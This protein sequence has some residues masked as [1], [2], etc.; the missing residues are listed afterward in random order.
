MEATP[1]AHQQTTGLRRYGMY[2]CMYV[3]MCICVSAHTRTRAH[4]HTHTHTHTG[5]LLSRKKNEILSFAAMLIDLE[6]IMLSE[7]GQRKTN[8][9]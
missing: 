5:I 3:S 7:I 2:V 8:T 6:N 9:T 1:S 4:T